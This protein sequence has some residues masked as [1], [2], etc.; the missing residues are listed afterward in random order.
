MSEPDASQGSR[1]AGRFGR[2]VLAL[3]VLLLIV[4][5]GALL[6]RQELATRVALAYLERQ[7]VTVH[8][9]TVTRLTPG[10]IE[11]QDIALGDNREVAA[12]RVA[13]APVF[14]GFDVAVG[15]VEI[16]GLR[17]RVDITGDAAPL[18]SLQP[19]LQRFTGG[20][21]SA[22]ETAT[23]SP[24]PP[25]KKAPAL[26]TITLTD[27]AIVFE[28]PS[29]PMTAA[30]AGGVTPTEDGSLEAHAVLSL[31]SDLGTAR[32]QLTGSRRSD[33]ALQVTG[34]VTDGHLA[35]QGFAVGAFSGELSADS[36]GGEIP[37]IDTR[38]DLNDLSYV[39][40]EGAPLTLAQG[41]LRI[42]GGLTGGEAALNLEGGDE[43]LD[44]KVSGHIESASADRQDVTLNV[45]GE[46]RSRGGL[47]QFIVLPGRQITTGTLVVQAEGHG[48]LP[49]TAASPAS[50]P[51]A[52][53]LLAQS[54]LTLTGD[55]ILADVALADGTSGISA[56]LPLETTIADDHL[57]VTLREDAAARVERPAAAVLRGL[58]VPDDLLPLVAS[59]LNLSLASGGDLPFRLAATPAWPPV[60]A[61]IAVAAEAFSAQGV[62]LGAK[63]EG[64]AALG[65]RFAL[66]RF[67]G[68]IE[69]RAEAKS[70][71]VGGRQARGI[72]LVLP[73]TA[74]YSDAGLHLA[75]ATPGRL[76]V[77]QFGA[78]A[79]LRLQQPLSFAIS[80]LSLESGA[81]DPGYAYRL[82][83]REDGVA[84]S[85]AADGSEPVAVDAD[86]ITLQADGRFEPETG[87]AASV[88][89]GLSGLALPGYDFTA[90]T[91]NIEVA[92][93]SDLRPRT[94]R[95]VLAPFQLGGAD[96]LTA[97]LS[98][99][100]TLKRK[101]AGYDI[102]AAVGLSG[103]Q[104][105][106]DL[107][108]RYDDDGTARIDAASRLL[109]FTPDG[110]QPAQISPLLDSLEKVSG[111]VTANASLA[112]PRDPSAQSGK[113]TV[114][115]LSF[116]GPAAVEGLD[117][118]L[119]LDSLLPLA[120]A[121]GQH[122]KI[123]RL[124]AGIPVED[125][126]IAFSL[127]QAPGPQLSVAS[128][129]F[130]LGGARWRIEPAILDPAAERN[131][132]V[133]A[134]DGL[135]LATLFELLGVDGLSGSGTLKGSLPIVFSDSDVIVDDGRFEAIAPG[136]LSIR[137]D[138]LRAALS[139]SG[140][141]VEM[142]VKA[143]EDF[144]YDTLSLTLEKTAANDATVQLSTLGQNPE[145]LD[146]QPFQFNINLES[147][148]TSV[149]NAL[150]QGY[151]LSDDALR[152]A[153]QLRQ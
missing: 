141:T 5:A 95:F 99:D 130:D 44:L 63:V 137:I 77:T 17:L 4:L 116:A 64:A 117:L 24:A 82:A 50:L 2:A 73:L 128:G 113:L 19:L 127:D 29:G 20:S 86:A 49:G 16:D 100:G 48:T 96:P 121:P 78:G 123:R 28:T 139:G 59:G 68:S 41:Q 23:P 56:H 124:E 147:N 85:L 26:P 15:R 148:L 45:E 150:K 21:G 67:D 134:T 32:S 66:D 98:L 151:S 69:A 90:E 65:N 70:L 38:F 62:T 111:T 8:S 35:W 101:G 132:I 6:F 31:D 112:W 129:G 60:A 46:V 53:A 34:Q 94:S 109:S 110:L 138:A 97:P 120:S 10:G 11:L 14:D 72:T 55:A 52:A 103:G 57:T 84:L 143:M 145:V 37:K 92:L 80:E 142:A 149:L 87:H 9:L 133:L 102:A 33:G 118:A 1:T 83:A 7:G 91:A 42:T 71:S 153:W 43:H 106:V 39:P 144:H 12:Q 104:T 22:D 75:L 89:I 40:D 3:G 108:G 61:E 47:A 81:G 136:R 18:G 131:R 76:G 115:G 27:A 114:S 126:D 79:P 107:T 105:L 146:G 54:R 119:T 25:S 122:L 135:D 36:D 88:T 140:E 51:A 125:I 13:V 93:D 30:L 58:G 74:D 152:R